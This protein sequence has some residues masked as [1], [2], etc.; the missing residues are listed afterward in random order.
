MN[1]KAE[2]NEMKAVMDRNEYRR[3]LVGNR[4][5]PKRTTIVLFDLDVEVMQPSFRSVVQTNDEH[6]DAERAADLIIR[7]VV[8]PGTDT[9]IFEEADIPEILEWPFSEDIVRLNEAITS[10]TG[11][12]IDAAKEAMVANPL[13][14]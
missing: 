13:S 6:N 10:L 7:Y 8:I 3:Q 12:N 5:K 9:R 11:I 14:E 2:A 1:Q 4:Q